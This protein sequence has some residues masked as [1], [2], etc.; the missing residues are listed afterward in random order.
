MKSK[1]CFFG[2]RG[3]CCVTKCCKDVGGIKHGNDFTAGRRKHCRICPYGVC[4]CVWC[5]GNFSH[6]LFILF[7]VVCFIGCIGAY[8]ITEYCVD[9]LWVKSEMYQVCVWVGMISQNYCYHHITLNDARIAEFCRLIDVDCARMELPF[10][11]PWMRCVLT[12]NDNDNANTIMM[13]IIISVTFTP[14]P[15]SRIH[16]KLLRTNNSFM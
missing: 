5:A 2:G 9:V 10:I 6:L 14:L 13:I 15:S 12:V 7:S 3:R 1:L 4:V 16:H 11:L 8:D